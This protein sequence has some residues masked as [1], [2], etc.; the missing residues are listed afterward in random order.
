MDKNYY[1]FAIIGTAPYWNM[2]TKIEMESIGTLSM[3]KILQQVGSF[4]FCLISR[5]FNIQEDNKCY[6]NYYQ[7]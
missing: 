3:C 7:F 1:G 4:G 2:T 6:L 5:N